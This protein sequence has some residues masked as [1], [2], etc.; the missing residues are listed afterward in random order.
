MK[1]MMTGK[2]LGMMAAMCFASGSVV[3]AQQDPLE[4]M[5]VMEQRI[6]Q[7]EERLAQYESRDNA[8]QT[9]LSRVQRQV[10]GVE[11]KIDDVQAPSDGSLITGIDMSVGATMV[12]QFTDKASGDSLS[13][14]SEDAGDASYSVDVEFTK[15]FEDYGAVLVLFEAGEGAGVEDELQVLS[16]VNF[17]ATGGDSN[18]GIVE[19]WYEQYVG[20]ATLRFGKLDATYLIDNNDYANDE[21]G[22]FLGRIFRNNPA[23]AF[24]DNGVGVRLAL[25][26]HDR[27]E[28]ESIAMDGDGDWDDV[29]EDLFYAGQINL[30]A[31]LWDRPGNYRF[32]AWASEADHVR[33]DDT[34]QAKEDNYG[35]GF[36]FD[37]ALTDDLGVF[38][39]YGWQN[40]DVYAAG[41]SESLE[42]SYSIGAQLAGRGWDREEDVIGLALGAVIPSDDYK[43]SNSALK[44]DTERHLE[45]YYS[46]KVNDHLTVS[47]DLQV[48]WDP[49]GGDAANG[50]KTIIVGGIRTQIDF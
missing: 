46:Y 13:K 43:N 10:D 40:P 31:N 5:A 49:Y 19:A 6:A 36:S 47:P 18:P 27:I 22:Q 17:D 39:R 34:A 2:G 44:A 48:I 14:N 15:E 37:Q 25:A 38:A 12:Y 21:A 1:F 35:F 11:Q 29:L 4:Q 3:S 26:P 41:A 50:D 20:P 24:A 23:V 32:Y 8:T 42:Q 45:L 9:Q 7:L 16:N 33:W 28:I 30:Q